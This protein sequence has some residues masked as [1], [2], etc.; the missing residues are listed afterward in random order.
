MAFLRMVEKSLETAAHGIATGATALADEM[1]GGQHPE[2]RQARQE[3]EQRMRAAA[4]GVEE[5]AKVVGKDLKPVVETTGVSLSVLVKMLSNKQQAERLGELLTKH[6][7]KALVKAL[8]HKGGPKL[9]PDFL[10][11]WMLKAEGYFPKFAQ[12]LS[13]RADLIQNAQVLEQLGRC[14][15]DM[16]PRGEAAV[17]VFVAEQSDIPRCQELSEGVGKALNAGSVAQVNEV[18][19]PGGGEA[20]VMKVAWGDTK[21]RMEVDFKL[22]KHARDILKAVDSKDF[23][24]QAVEAMFAAVGRSKVAVLAEFDLTREAGAMKSIGELCKPGGE[25]EAVYRIWVEAANQMLDTVPP[26]LAMMGR[27][28]LP[29]LSQ[30]QVAVPQPLE[31]YCGESVMCMSRAGGLSMHQIIRGEEGEGGGTKNEAGGVLLTLAIPFIGWLLLMK[32]T[33]HLAHVDPHPGNFRWDANEKTLWVLDWGSHTN[34]SEER[35]R[36]LCQLV[37]ILADPCSGEDVDSQIAECGRTFGL[38]SANDADLARLVRGLF[39]ATSNHS[40]Q[41]ALSA[42]ALD[43]ILESVDENVVTVVRCLAILGGLMKK[44]QVKLQPL[45]YGELPEGAGARQAEMPLSLAAIWRPFA[46]MGLQ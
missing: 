23:K 20:A 18:E 21:K 27:G 33:S 13:V 14:L 11:N 45:L 42:A 4:R 38:K 15:E 19:V 8:V 29:W 26:H 46:S 25:W 35:R 17:K 32:S 1:T 3:Q 16:A 6:D 12:V 10:P 7:F 43:G 40:A 39:N 30:C 28:M 22:F 2:L 5:N 44:M 37:I 24:A 41:E 34:L 31:E 36:A 9:E